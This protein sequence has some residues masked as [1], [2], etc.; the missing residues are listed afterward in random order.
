MII[1]AS[2][3]PLAGAICLL[4]AIAEGWIM[5]LIRYADLRPLK[6]RFPGYRYLARSH[7][8]FAVMAALLFGIYLLQAG[9]DLSL[10]ALTVAALIIGALYD[11]FGFFLQA[12]KPDIAESDA[13][14]M[15]LLIL[16]GFIPATYGF[17]AVGLAVL[18]HRW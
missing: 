3:L 10:S 7:V 5:A 11:P 15:K 2:L 16:A 14:L 12:L 18:M 8:D 9:M 6:R 4:A 17:G 13:P 1:N